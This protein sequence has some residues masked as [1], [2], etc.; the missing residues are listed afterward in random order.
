MLLLIGIGAALAVGGVLA[1][2][3]S[4]HAWLGLP[5]LVLGGWAWV[6]AATL[7]ADDSDWLTDFGQAQDLAKQQGK[8]LLVDGWAKWCTACLELSKVTF[9]DPA[10]RKRLESF[11]RVKLDMDQPANQP[12]WDQY[13]IPGLPWVAFFAPDGTYQAQHLLNSFEEPQAFATRLDRALG[14]AAGAAEREDIAGRLAR[15]GLLLTLLFVFLAGIGVSFT[16]CVYPIIPITL[17]VIGARATSGLRHRLALALTFVGGL[18]VTYTTLGLVAG[19]TGA[20]LGTA[21]QNPLVTGGIALLFMAMGLSYLD[22][23]T[24]EMPLALQDRLSGKGGA[25]FAGALVTGLVSGLVAAPCAGPVTVAILAYIASTRDPALGLA[26]MLAF[27]LGLGLLFVVLGT[28]T[29]LTRRLPRGGS[30]MDGLKRVFAVVLVVVGLYYA[31]LALPL[32]NAPWHW[33]AAM[34]GQ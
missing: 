18:A 9:K 25:G 14:K 5:L 15:S 26:L 11:V 10:V 24:L 32:I 3:L 29:E 17:S 30:W 1:W 22:L 19:F 7:P 12:L 6:N 23:F 27:S 33:L 21:M 31:G 28:S 13:S 2:R 4:H 16:P 20:G 8:P 34:A